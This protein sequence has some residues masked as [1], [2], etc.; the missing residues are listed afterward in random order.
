[1]NSLLL[2]KQIITLGL[3]VIGLNIMSLFAVLFGISV[4]IT[5]NPI[6]SILF[7]IGLFMCIASLLSL[8]GL[9][10]IALSY[11]LVYVGAVSILFLFILML[12]NVRVSEILSQNIQSLPLA[13]NTIYL[14]GVSTILNHLRY[15]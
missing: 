9:N 5:K 10:F 3:S 6:S 8:M 13:N 11:I 4:I 14:S 7:L 2:F 1:M 12:I 15:Q